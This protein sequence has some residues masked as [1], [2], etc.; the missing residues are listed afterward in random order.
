MAVKDQ[1][2]GAR[3]ILKELDDESRRKLKETEA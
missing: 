2:F 3:H 1:Q